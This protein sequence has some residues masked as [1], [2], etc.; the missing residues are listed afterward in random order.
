M[1]ALHLKFNLFLSLDFSLT[2][3]SARIWCS[4][5]AFEVLT[6]RR[7]ERGLTSFVSSLFFSYAGFTLRFQREKVFRRCRT[8]HELDLPWSAPRRSFAAL[9]TFTIRNNRRIFATSSVD[10]RNR[11]CCELLF[12]SFRMINEINIIRFDT[13]ARFRMRIKAECLR[14]WRVGMK[15]VKKHLTLFNAFPDAAT[16]AAESRAAR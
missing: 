6:R 15:R 14:R 9:Y 16:R 4:W 5:S 10:W 3:I 1:L 12:R 11:K 13:K 7:L 2:S 8:W